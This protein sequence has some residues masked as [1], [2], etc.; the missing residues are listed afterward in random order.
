MCLL[1]PYKGSEV[2]TDWNVPRMEGWPSWLLEVNP[3]AR[4]A[5]LQGRS[6]ITWSLVRL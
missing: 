1:T 2:G 3:R 4:R 5:G 6:E